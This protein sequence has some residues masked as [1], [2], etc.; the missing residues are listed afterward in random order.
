MSLASSK[1]PSTSLIHKLR[2]TN[3]QINSLSMQKQL[4]K[5]FQKMLIGV[6]L[7]YPRVTVAMEDPPFIKGVP[8]KIY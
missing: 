8:I 3:V 5:T 1:R 4:R 7:V 2:V 6:D